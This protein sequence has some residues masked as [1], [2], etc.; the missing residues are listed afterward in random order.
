METIIEKLFK[1]IDE[2]TK[3]LQAENGHSFIENLG[4]SLEDLYLNQRELLEQGTTADRRKAFQ[5]AYLS[6]LKEE[7]IQPNHQMTPDSIGY[8]VSYIVRMFIG[9]EEQLTLLDLTSGTGHLSATVNEQNP[10]KTIEHLLIDVDPVLTRLSVHLANYLEIPFNVYPQDA[11]MQL[12]VED[13]D[14]VIGDLPVGYYPVDERSHE[15]KLGFKEGHS[16]SHHLLIEQAVNALKPGGTAF[17]IVP[18][19]LFEFDKV[20]Q[21][22][23]FIATETVM[24][25]FLNF[26]ASLFKTESARKSLLIIEKK[27]DKKAPPVEVLL[28]NI[29]DFKDEYKMKAFLDE[30]N[31]WF[32]NNRKN[33]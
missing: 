11:M 23:K 32:E 28:A 7:M 31:Q 2:K 18:S 16:F 25:A 20:E 21:L 10:D 17:L 5:F 33:K 13:V 26:P 30:F 12:P 14:M 8:L 9:E 19:Q 29:P 27:T 24:Q 1:V 3:A 4:F 6:L 22:Q 15:M